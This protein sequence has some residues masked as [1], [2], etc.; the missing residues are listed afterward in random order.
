MNSG[1]TD[2]TL[3]EAIEGL[4]TKMRMEHD[5]AW[6]AG[7][8]ALVQEMMLAAAQTA[9]QR[10]EV[11]RTQFYG[12]LLPL[13]PEPAQQPAMLHSE[14]VGQTVNGH[15]NDPFPFDEEYEN[16]K[17]MNGGRG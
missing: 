14:P 10:S 5:P 8:H 11:A 6:Q 13:L 12:A 15:H 1:Y 4:R 16:P 2:H 17:F 7:V 3:T 9:I